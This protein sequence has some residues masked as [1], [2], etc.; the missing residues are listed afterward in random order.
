M[1]MQVTAVSHTVAF[2]ASAVVQMRNPR[3][4]RI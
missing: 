2:A 4:V 1:N 3:W